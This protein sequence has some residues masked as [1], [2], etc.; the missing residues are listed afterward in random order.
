MLLKSVVCGDIIPAKISLSSS[1]ELYLRYSQGH[2][3]VTTLEQH[4]HSLTQLVIE[5]TLYACVVEMTFVHYVGI[6]HNNVLPVVEAM[7]G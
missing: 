3:N 1:S 2:F 4:K 5:C 7:M 6:L